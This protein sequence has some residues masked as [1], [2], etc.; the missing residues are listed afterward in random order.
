MWILLDY[1]AFA[2]DLQK[3]NFFRAAF[4]GF[5]FLLRGRDLGA[6]RLMLLSS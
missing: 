3:K 2:H 6:F 4:S 1:H 5:N